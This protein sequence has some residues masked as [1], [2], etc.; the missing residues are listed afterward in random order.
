MKTPVSESL[1]NKIKKKFNTGAFLKLRIFLELLFLQKT[2]GGCFFIFRPI[3]SF[4]SPMKIPENLD[5]FC[6]NKE[7]TM[8]WNDLHFGENL[9]TWVSFQV[10]PNCQSK[11]RKKSKCSPYQLINLNRV[12][13]KQ[14]RHIN[15]FHGSGIFLYPLNT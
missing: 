1:F 5:K 12:S 7:G 11:S 4:L 15:K 8:D 6:G 10:G 3:S 14:Q 13:R 9:V 2:S